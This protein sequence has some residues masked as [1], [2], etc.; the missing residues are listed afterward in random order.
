MKKNKG[1]L[2]LLVTVL[3]INSLGYISL[4]YDAYDFGL[5]FPKNVLNRLVWLKQ[6]WRNEIHRLSLLKW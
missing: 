3:L 2:A 4:I 1:V 5:E 6:Y